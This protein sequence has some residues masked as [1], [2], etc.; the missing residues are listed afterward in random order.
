M[1]HDRQEPEQFRKLFIGGLSYETTEDSLRSYFEKWGTIVDCVVMRDPNTKRSRGFGFITYDRANQLDDA[2][3][4]RPH[5]IDKKEVETK[6]ATPREESGKPEAHMTIK[7]IFVG[8]VKEDVEEPDLRDYFSQ[9]GNIES[10]DI[11]IDKQTQKKRGFAFV[12]F[13]DYDPVDK[14]VLTKSH[15]IRGKRCDVK[16]A[17]DKKELANMPQRGGDRGGRGGDRGGRGGGRGGGGRFGDRGGN[18]GG[19]GGGGSYGNSYGGGGGGYNGEQQNTE[20]N[21]QNSYS[22]NNYGGGGGGGGDSWGGNQGG[23]SW[24]GGNQGGN[25]WGGG[26]QS[27]GNSSWGGGAQS[28]GGYDNNSYGEAQTSGGNW[29]SGGGNNYGGNQGYQGNDTSYNQGGGGGGGAMRQGG[30]QNFSG[31][32]RS[33][34]PYGGG[35]GSSGGGGGYSGG[36]GNYGGGYNR[37]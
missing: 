10:V 19:G 29:N 37:R 24:S 35:Y 11:I 16:K 23:S 33:S 7:K 31:G 9:Y 3:A 26:A 36:G 27:G 4:N 21:T 12:A 34:G 5:T 20:S 18:F 8:G 25:S 14:I 30:G 1:S 17:V 2:Q 22:S 28:S 15:Q 32:Q 6:R 13:D